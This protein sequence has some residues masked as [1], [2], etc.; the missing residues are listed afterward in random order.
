[1]NLSFN[2]RMLGYLLIVVLS[3]R[4]FAAQVLWKTLLSYRVC[5]SFCFKWRKKRQF[6]NQ[7]RLHRFYWPLAR[8]CLC[9]TASAKVC[10]TDSV[11]CHEMQASVILTPCLR[12]ALPSGGTFWLP[13]C[14]V[15]LYSHRKPTYGV[16]VI[17]TLVDVALNH[18]SHNGILTLADLIGQF[19][20]HL[21]LVLVVLQ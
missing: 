9:F 7:T 20:R 15:S 2:A 13:A 4:L 16:D 8:F 1:M 18:H 11:S 17:L 14:P 19:C 6:I 10:R 3:Y 21:W 12:P 5:M